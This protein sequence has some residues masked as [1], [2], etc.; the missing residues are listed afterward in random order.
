MNRAA[1]TRYRQ[2][3]W[4]PTWP[5][6][7]LAMLC[8]GCGGESTTAKKPADAAPKTSADAG[9][10]VKTPG[11][12]D[13][14]ATTGGLAAQLGELFVAQESGEEAIIELHVATLGLP[15]PRTWFRDHFG[16]KRARRLVRGYQP[17]ADNLEQ[18]AN[19]MKKLRSDGLSEL[20]VSKH[21]LVDDY[22]AVVY[23]TRALKVMQIAAPLYSVRFQSKPKDK[24]F[25]LWSFVHVDGR[26]RYVG[27][28]KTLAKADK[29][30]GRDLNEFRPADAAKLRAAAGDK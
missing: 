9:M 15:K 30:G 2:H 18:V 26:F 24:V 21:Q 14:P 16:A 3:L 7:A 22:Q 5:L 29:V 10:I 20:A 19:L 1:A 11:P 23:Q 17:I 27:K 4:L 25:H 28:M 6:A 13:H 12:Q 8:G